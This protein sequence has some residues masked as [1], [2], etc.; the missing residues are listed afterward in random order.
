LGLHGLAGWDYRPILIPGARRLAG[1][2]M[3]VPDTGF[4]NCKRFRD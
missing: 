1:F 3:S 4:S 2:L